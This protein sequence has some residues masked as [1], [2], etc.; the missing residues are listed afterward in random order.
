MAEAPDGSSVDVRKCQDAVYAC[1]S[2]NPILLALQ[3]LRAPEVVVAPA[4]A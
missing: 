4:A 2:A 3:Y 1:H